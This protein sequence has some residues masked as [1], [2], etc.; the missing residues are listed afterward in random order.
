M[1]AGGG[2]ISLRKTLVTCLTLSTRRP[3]LTPSI[4]TT[5]TRVRSVSS[6]RSMPKRVRMSMTGRTTPR[7]LAMPS[8]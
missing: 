2:S 7:K 1:A 3:V 6:A 5:K 8:T 4:S